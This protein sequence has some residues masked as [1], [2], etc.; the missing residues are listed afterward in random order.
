M[1]NR[2][3]FQ[4]QWKNH[5]SW[6]MTCDDLTMYYQVRVVPL[7]NHQWFAGGVINDSHSALTGCVFRP[8]K[9]FQW[10][11]F[12]EFSS[13]ISETLG[14]RRGFAEQESSLPAKPLGLCSGEIN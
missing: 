6:L 10:V 2:D 11:P 8:C 4:D 5:F 13:T 7:F 9:L 3:K 1:L 14:M 12:G